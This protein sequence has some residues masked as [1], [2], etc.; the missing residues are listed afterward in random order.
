[1]TITLEPEILTRLRERA[2]REQQTPEALANALLSDALADD[3][4]DLTEAEKAEIRAGIDRG[5]KAAAEGRER[6]LAEWA[7]Q[8]RRE[9]NL[10]THLTDAEKTEIRAGIERGLQAAAEGRERPI[11]EYIAEVQKRRM[12]RIP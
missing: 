1:M 11:D 8:L 4:D 3:P 2:A 10:P 12:R 6:P 7:A 5:L 9:Y